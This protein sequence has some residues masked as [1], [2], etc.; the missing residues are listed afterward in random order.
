ME[1][2]GTGP[3]RHGSH[4]SRDRYV[5]ATA[6]RAQ[7][8]RFG[9]GETRSGSTRTV[10]AR[11]TDSS[12]FAASKCRDRLPF[13][14]S[15]RERAV[16]LRDGTGGRRNAGDACSPDRAARRAHDHRHRLAGQQRAGRSG[17]A[18]FRAPRFET[19]KSDVG[20]SRDAEATRFSPGRMR[21]GVAPLVK[22]ID[23]GVAKALVEKPDAMGLTHGG[24]V[25]TPAFA[26][27][28]QF[29]DAPVGVRSDIYSLGATLWYLLTGTQTFRGCDHRTDSREPAL[30]S[31]ADRT[32]E[33]S[34]CSKPP[35][36]AARVDACPRTSSA[37]ECP[38]THVAIA[39]LPRTDSRPLEIGA[40]I[41]SCGRCDRDRRC[42]LRTIPSLA[43]SNRVA[44]CGACKRP[45][46]EHCGSTVSKSLRRQRQCVFR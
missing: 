43:Q 11:S 2:L 41:G 37:P 19:G 36:F 22:V 29:T 3:R 4:I 12:I 5:A 40:P 24:F 25:G 30:A 17:K 14:Y 39:K 6:G 28:E 42:R 16:L 10:H 33:G 8:Y 46:K 31:S 38:C 15:R 27:P 20:R 7:A 9:M 23:F 1:R 21:E 35:Y 26:S 45:R 44:E 13:R 34:T 18:R 32:A